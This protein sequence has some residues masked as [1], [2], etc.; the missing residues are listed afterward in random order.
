[1]RYS[2]SV[3][4]P[5]SIH[6]CLEPSF[7]VFAPF[8]SSTPFTAFIVSLIVVLTMHASASP[9]K[10]LIDFEN[11]FNT[12][13]WQVVNDDVMGGVSTSRFGVETNRAI[14][15]GTVSLENNGGFA[16]VRSPL[17][18]HGAGAFSTFVVRVKGDGHRY[19]F[20][21]RTGAGFDKPQYQASFETRPGEWQELHFPIKDFVP[22]WRGRV[23]TGVPPI[24]PAAP[25]AIGFLISD[26]QSGPFKLEIGR[27][28]IR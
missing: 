28:G 13:G 17:Q 11:P 25:M 7:S 26:K 16:S 21:I 9:G 2:R 3:P 5:A 4:N 18:D 15:S 24:D 10:R 19:K 20:T 27:I 1:M 6:R 8:P 23:L 22:S 12:S 14:F